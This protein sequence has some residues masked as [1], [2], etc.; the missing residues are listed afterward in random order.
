MHWL[1]KDVDS[2]ESV[3]GRFAKVFDGMAIQSVNPNGKTIIIRAWNIDICYQ[4]FYDVW[5]KSAHW[6]SKVDI[7]T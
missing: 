3:E 4:P 6:F 1:E 2:E 7:L 5:I